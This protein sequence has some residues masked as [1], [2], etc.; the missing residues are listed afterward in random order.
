VIEKAPGI[1]AAFSRATLNAAETAF[2]KRCSKREIAASYE[3][4]DV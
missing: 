3:L 2:N 4:R 1:T